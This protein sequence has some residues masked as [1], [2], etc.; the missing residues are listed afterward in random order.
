[1]TATGATSSSKKPAK[2][3]P[4]PIPSQECSSRVVV[5]GGMEDKSVIG[6]TLSAGGLYL[7]H[8]SSSEC[9]AGIEYCNPH[10]LLRPGRQMPKIEELSISNGDERGQLSSDILDEVTKSRLLRV[11][12]NASDATMMSP[13]VQQSS[14]IRTALKE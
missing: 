4:L 9:D 14:R 8:P 2:G 12:D 11:L 6:D 13:A 1:M 3:K 10:Y 7:Q 5:F